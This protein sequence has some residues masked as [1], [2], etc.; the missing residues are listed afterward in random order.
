M[1]TISQRMKLYFFD[2]FLH[3]QFML[4]ATIDLCDLSK[5][6]KRILVVNVACD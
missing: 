4:L 1:Y 3:S 6:T 5:T 2:F